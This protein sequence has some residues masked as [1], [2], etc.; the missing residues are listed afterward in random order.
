MKK[1][2]AENQLEAL[3]SKNP[4]AIAYAAEKNKKIVEA[5]INEMANRNRNKREFWLK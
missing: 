2:E 1:I 4:K 5:Q 3:E